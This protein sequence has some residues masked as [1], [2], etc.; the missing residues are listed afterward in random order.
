MKNNKDNS[1][2]EQHCGSMVKESHGTPLNSPAPE[3]TSI[4]ELEKGCGKEW[5]SRTMRFAECNKDYLCPICEA[6][7]QQA[8]DDRK[9]FK[10]FMEQFDLGWNEECYTI[11]KVTFER[12]MEGKE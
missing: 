5:E 6:K 10:E 12:E 8:K 2:K 9:K 1:P 11:A 4:E 7:L 3:G